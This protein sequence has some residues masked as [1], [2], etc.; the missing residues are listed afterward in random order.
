MKERMQKT[1]AQANDVIGNF[2]S[3]KNSKVTK[4]RLRQYD[5]CI[6]RMVP[7][8][9]TAVCRTARTVV[10]CCESLKLVTGLKMGVGPPLSIS[11]FW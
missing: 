3:S 6:S 11:R 2:V 1:S 4:C 10:V 8:I 9:G 7:K 5:G